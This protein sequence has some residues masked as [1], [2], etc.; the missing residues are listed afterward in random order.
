MSNPTQ[1]PFKDGANLLEEASVTILRTY[2][3]NQVA[4]FERLVK[5]NEVQ[6]SLYVVA[7]PARDAPIREFFCARLLDLQ[8][9]TKPLAPVTD[10]QLTALTAEVVNHRLN[11]GLLD[12]WG[13][14]VGRLNVC[15]QQPALAGF[16]QDLGA[17][18]IPCAIE[19]INRLVAALGNREA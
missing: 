17:P 14:E 7:L 13:L 15:L 11:G 5:K 1:S 10:L 8:D 3:E 19:T 16:T 12:K 2:V 6:A 18:V 4:H 9:D